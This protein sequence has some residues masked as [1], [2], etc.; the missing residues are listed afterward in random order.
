MKHACS[1]V[2]TN[3]NEKPFNGA[4]ADDAGIRLDQE[5]N[6]MHLTECVVSSKPNRTVCK[7]AIRCNGAFNGNLLVK[8]LAI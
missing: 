7:Y 3:F 2:D 6:D 8:I 1:K 5:P 4:G